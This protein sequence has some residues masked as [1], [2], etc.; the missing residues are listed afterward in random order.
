MYI[1]PYAGKTGTIDGVIRAKFP[2]LRS[3]RLKPIYRCFLFTG[4]RGH[5]QDRLGRPTGE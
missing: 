3:G 5:R 1:S 4:P 2:D